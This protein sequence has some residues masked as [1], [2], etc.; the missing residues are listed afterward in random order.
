[1][2]HIRTQAVHAGQKPDPVTGAIATGIA[3]TTAFAYGTLEHGA[4]LF[5]HEAKGW[6]YSRS[7]NPTT[8]ALEAKLA[9]LEGGEAAVV[10]GT[11]MAAVSAVVL[12]LMQPGDEIA[13]LGP[14]YGGTE[15]HFRGLSER[16]GIRVV[17]VP[18][19]GLAA[20]LSN[21]TKLIWVESP[22]NPTL[23]LNDLGAVA[24]IA[25]ARGVL[26][27]ADSTFCTPCL[28]RPIE[29]GIDL[30]LHSMTK[31]IGGHGDAIGGV[32]VGPEHIVA[33]V[34]QTGLNHLGGSISPH[35]AFLFLRGLQTLPLRMLAHCE[36]AAR[37]ASFLD[38]HPAVHR[39]FYPGLPSHPNHALAR[40][41]MTGGFG[42][43]VSFEL[44]Q[45]GRSAAAAL[46]N[47][48]KLFTQAVSLGDV[49]SLACHPASTTH[50]FIPAE[51]RALHGIGEGLIRLSVGIEHPDDL[52]ADLNQA[53]ENMVGTAAGASESGVLLPPA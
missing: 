39:V 12:G 36:G 18:E 26:T 11:G 47:G 17:A 10:F 29:H 48:L 1:M 38:A 9:A 6:T 5:A 34:R 4:A 52:I 40:R 31:Y 45:Q 46:L 14:L 16:F 15:S 3:Q 23:C 30:V 49:N 53:L 50:S 25:R 51:A 37:V 13:F 19:G 21:A 24:A 27:V 41:Q 43:I 8:A 2:T 32:V 44:V 42:G 33:S 20:S 7:G 35:T 22:T 28:T